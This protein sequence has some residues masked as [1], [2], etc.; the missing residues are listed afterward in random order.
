MA[1]MVRVL[2]VSTVEG[3]VQ[4]KGTLGW[5]AAVVLWQ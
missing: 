3:E 4:E 1:E 5:L 2:S